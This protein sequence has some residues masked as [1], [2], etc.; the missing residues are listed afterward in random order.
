MTCSDKV[1][2]SKLTQLNPTIFSALLTKL[3]VLT[4]KPDTSLQAKPTPAQTKEKN[5]QHWTNCY[6][7]LRTSLT[8]MK[9]FEDTPAAKVNV[10]Y[11]DK[12][13]IV[14]VSATN[15]NDLISLYGSDYP[16]S[17]CD[18]PVTEADDAAGNSLQCASCRLY[19]HTTK[20]S[21]KVEY[22]LTA[23]LSKALADHAP[24]NVCV[25]CPKCML[26]NKPVTLAKLSEKMDHLQGLTKL[27]KQMDFMQGE[28]NALKLNQSD[29][30]PAL[31]TSPPPSLE[32]VEKTDYVLLISPQ[33]AGDDDSENAPTF[34]QTSWKDV[35]TGDFS[36]KLADVPVSKSVLNKEGQGVLAFKTKEDSDTAKA[37]LGEE[38][39]IVEDTVVK[40][41]IYPKLRLIEID[42]DKY[43][44]ENK[45]VLVKD[46]LTKNREIANLV[47]SENCLLEVI[48]IQSGEIGYS[49]AI[50]KV[51]P[52][53][54]H[55]IMKTD[56]S[57]HLDMSIIHVRDQIHVTQCFDCQKF[58]HKRQSPD[59][60]ALPH[61]VICLYC[62]GNHKSSMCTLKKNK[63]KHVCANCSTSNIE[64]HRNNKNH[65]STN[66]NCPFIQRQRNLIISRTAGLDPKNLFEQ[67]TI[68][69]RTPSW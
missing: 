34:D 13:S 60:K 61:K 69:R 12:G 32:V 66:I 49:D 5:K 67:R 10:S 57:I 48:Y 44:N 2:E 22:L 64:T 41:Q 1:T 55:A 3:N 40:S 35:V 39:K 14:D 20:C 43:N 29:P 8:Y 4:P 46:I 6:N 31:I 18:N 21:D 16:C 47:N 36:E 45:A 25:Y 26:N 24:A 15:G 54:R 56:K 30:R 42:G 23:D 53:I 51:H 50:L 52:K 27:S 11:N 33:S 68:N 17:V 63:D 58:G 19:W 28:L 37:A 38:F 65:S 62:T 59:C 7:N 9:L